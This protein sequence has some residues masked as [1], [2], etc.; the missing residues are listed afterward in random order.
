[1]HEV[2]VSDPPAGRALPAASLLETTATEFT[3]CAEPGILPDASAGHD[4]TLL[5]TALAEIAARQMAL[6]W[7]LEHDLLCRCLV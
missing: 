2:L 1:M 5:A 7:L 6:E 4:A 3:C